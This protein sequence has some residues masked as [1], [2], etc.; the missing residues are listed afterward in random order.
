MPLRIDN[1]G[2]LRE[3]Q[4]ALFNINSTAGWLLLNY[5]RRWVGLGSKAVTQHLFFNKLIL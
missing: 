5:V 4:A 2:E 3:A 1:E